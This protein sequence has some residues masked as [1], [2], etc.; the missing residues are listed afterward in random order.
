M[1]HD[2]PVTLAKYGK[3][4]NLLNEPGWKRLKHYV[5]SSKRLERNIK[6]ARMLAAST[7]L[8]YKFGVQVPCDKKEA[9]KFDELSGNKLWDKAIKAELD[10]IIEEYKT[11][12]DLGKYKSKSQIPRDHQLIKV[13]MVFD[14]KHDLQHKCR[15]VAGGHLTTPNG[16]KSY[17]SVASLRSIRLVTFVAVLNGLE[18][19]AANVCNA[20]L[21][22][23][24]NEK[25]CFVAGPSFA[26]YGMEDHLLV[27][28]KALYGLKN[29]GACH[30]AKWADSMNNFVFC[31]SYVDP[32]VWMRDK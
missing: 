19:E 30:H 8:R 32:D 2:D 6:Q 12:C 7:K 20:Y 22:P 16:D 29:S 1:R 15:L 21:E 13:N 17:S 4:N 31:P 25:V 10:Q 23:K 24:T 27:I 11:F 5:K 9:R 28:D 3:E 14:V 26:Q 18:L